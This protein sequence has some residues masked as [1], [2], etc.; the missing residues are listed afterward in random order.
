MD[1]SEY[2]H[3]P[4]YREG[5]LVPLLCFCLTID[6]WKLQQAFVAV[7]L[8]KLMPNLLF[9]VIH[10]SC[11]EWLLPSSSYVCL[12][13]VL[14]FRTRAGNR[15]KFCSIAVRAQVFSSSLFLEF[16]NKLGF[17]CSHPYVTIEPVIFFVLLGSW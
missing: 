17:W 16:Y 15:A 1:N 7:S 13:L 5:I 6:S 10:K 9:T 2:A 8:W 4:A 3:I 11:S 14:Y 12:R